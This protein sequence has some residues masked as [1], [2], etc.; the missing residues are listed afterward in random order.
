MVDRAEDN[1]YLEYKVNY[2]NY[3]MCILLIEQIY[4][5]EEL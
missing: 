3:L 2:I 4:I 5:T 1:L